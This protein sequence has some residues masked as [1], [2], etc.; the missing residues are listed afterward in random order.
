MSALDPR[1]LHYARATRTFLLASVAL[2]V[3]A[4]LLIVAQA[5]LLADVVARAFL[6]GEGAS[7]L[8]TPL[9]LAAARRPG[10]CRRRLGG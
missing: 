6:G 8:R 4:A 10:A 5:W 2:G 1:L 9:I 7:A 3:L